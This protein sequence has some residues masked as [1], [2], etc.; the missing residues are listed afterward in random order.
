MSEIKDGGPAFPNLKANDSGPRDARNAGMSLRDWF[1]SNADVSGISFA[2]S[3]EGAIWMGEPCPGP[4][5]F[6][7]LI[8]LNA[9][10]IARLKYIMADAMLAERER[11]Q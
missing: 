3:A 6:D 5:D 10:L 1:A 2:N 11:R 7:A 4:E 9:R 8:G